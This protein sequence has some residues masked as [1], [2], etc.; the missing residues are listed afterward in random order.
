MTLVFKLDEFALAGS[1]WLCRMFAFQCLDTCLF[2]VAHNMR[3]LRFELWRLFVRVADGL[4][5]LSVLLGVVLLIRRG[6]PVAALMR[7][8]LRFFLKSD[9]PDG[10]KCYRRSLA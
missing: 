5:V 8:E 3:A 4:H 10:A 6:E 7:P 2:V 1:R 9:R